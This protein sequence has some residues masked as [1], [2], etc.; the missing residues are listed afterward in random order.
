MLTGAAEGRA[1]VQA[2]VMGVSDYLLK[3][4]FSVDQLLSAVKSALEPRPPSHSEAS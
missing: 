4:S 3:S 2:G 1:V